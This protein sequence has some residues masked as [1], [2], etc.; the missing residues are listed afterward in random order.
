MSRSFATRVCL[1]LF[2]CLCALSVAKVCIQD[3]PSIK[4]RIFKANDILPLYWSSRLWLGSQNPYA[5]SILAGEMYRSN[6]ER[7]QV[8]RGLC[9]DDCQ[10]YYPPTAL[11]I[12]AVFTRIPW[13]VFLFVYMALCVGVYAFCLFKLSS[14]LENRWQRFLFWGLG[15]SLSP[16][17]AGIRSCNVSVLLIPVVLLCMLWK[18]N[19]VSAAVMGIVACI[20][21]PLAVLFVG[22]YIVSG[23][24]RKAA[25]SIGVVATVSLVSLIWLRHTGWFSAYELALSHFSAATNGPGGVLDHGVVNFG[26]SNLQGFFY[27]LTKDVR[28]A[29]MCDYLTLIFLYGALMAPFVIRSLRATGRSQLVVISALCGLTL[30]LPTLQYY[31]GIFLLGPAVYALRSRSRSVQIALL[32]AL[33]T[34]MLPPRWF[35]VL[36]QLGQRSLVDIARLT[37]VNHGQLDLGHQLTYAQQ[38][39]LCVPSLL[40]TLISCTLIVSFYKQY[41]GVRYHSAESH[42]QSSSL[43]QDAFLSRTL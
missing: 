26:F 27:L 38:L 28:W 30:L 1:A 32:A 18:D 13:R 17:H 21:P 7:F 33:S 39:L 36:Q 11:P 23:Q 31:N 6:P 14:L 34:F 24:R 35:L 22:Y 29:V 19:L 40:A 9:G 43:A 20:K 42:D 5:P 37:Q 10:V 15:L 12:F 41:R 16:F 25:A 3:L 4:S 8:T 2:I